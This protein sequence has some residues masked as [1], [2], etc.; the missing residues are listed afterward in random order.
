[1]ISYVGILCY[2]EKMSGKHL[3]MKTDHQDNAHWGK[4]LEVKYGWRG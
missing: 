2:H 1:M 3:K 4:N